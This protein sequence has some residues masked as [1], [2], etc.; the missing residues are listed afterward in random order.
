MEGSESAGGKVWRGKKKY[1][2]R[3]GKRDPDAFS[4]EGHITYQMQSTSSSVFIPL[5]TH[6]CACIL[7]TGLF[8]FEYFECNR[9]G[10]PLISTNHMNLAF[11][12]RYVTE[13]FCLYK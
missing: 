12:V 7:D 8:S 11:N 1:K 4:G 13:H 10:Y 3:P 2:S 9:R 6:L 5:H